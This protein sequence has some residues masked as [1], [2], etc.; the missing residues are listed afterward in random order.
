MLM[1]TFEVAEKLR[2]DIETVRRLIQQK[3]LKAYKVG[4]SWRVYPEDL[5]AF[6]KERSNQ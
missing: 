6:V 2:V 5:D 4:N 3:K 1:T